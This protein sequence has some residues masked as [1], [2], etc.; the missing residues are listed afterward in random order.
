MR[1]RWLKLAVF[2]SFLLTVHSATSE[3]KH[4]PTSTTIIPDSLSSCTVRDWKRV[5]HA[6]LSQMQTPVCPLPM[7][8]VQENNR[9]TTLKTTKQTPSPTVTVSDEKSQDLNDPDTD[10][11]LDNANFLSFDEWKKQNLA[12]IGQSVE[13]VRGNRRASD[14][15]KES[16]RRPTGI[17]NAL[18][19]F[20]DE[21]EIEINFAGF[22]AEPPNTA[23][24]SSASWTAVKDEEEDE[25][26]QP[27]Q[28]Q[29]VD[30]K[31][32]DDG[33]ISPPSVEWTGTSRE[34]DAGT[35]CK[36]RFNYASF[37]CAATVLKTNPQCQGS[38]SVLVEN[39]D[40][41]MLNEC[42]A[43]DKLLILELCDDIL[44]DTVVLAN[45]EFFSSIF[46][47]FR[48][49]VSDRYPAKQPGQWKELGVY[50]ARNTREVQAFP[51][52]NPLIWARYLKIEFLTHYGTEFYCPLSLVRV[53]GTTMME[54]Y[55][56]DWETGRLDDGI[57]E[58]AE[59]EA[60]AAVPLESND[61]E[62]IESPEPPA[63]SEEE[64]NQ[65]EQHS[66]A[67]IIGS[68][69]NIQA[70][71]IRV[72]LGSSCAVI[73]VC[74]ASENTTVTVG[75]GGDGEVDNITE[76]VQTSI[77]SA[78]ATVESSSVV[79]STTTVVTSTDMDRVIPKATETTIISSTSTR[80]V[81]SETVIRNATETETKSTT[82]PTTTK[83]EPT[84][85]TG[86]SETRPTVAQPSPHPTTQESF[87]KSVNK[88]LQMLETNS[89]LSLLYIE[90]QSRILREAFQKVEKRQLTKTST[91]L[92]N[93]NTTVLGEL[94]Q[95]REQ[96]EDVWNLVTVEFNN[97]KL[98]YHKEIFSFSSQLSL[99]TDELVF[100]KRLSVI[101]SIVVLFCF[102]FVVFS[103]PSS[104]QPYGRRSA[105]SRPRIRTMIHPTRSSLLSFV[106]S[107]SPS[108]TSST[109][110]P[111][112]Y[113]RDTDRDDSTQSR[114]I[115]H[116]DSQEDEDDD[117][118]YADADGEVDADADADTDGINID[119][120][121]ATATRTTPRSSEDSV[122]EKIQVV[123]DSSPED[124]VV[125][126]QRSESSPPVLS[127]GV[128]GVD[129][130]DDH[131]IG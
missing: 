76:P 4:I 102:G 39:K 38:S 6:E 111:S 71:V 91:F 82:K 50:E 54:E 18:E 126:A 106:G 49:S 101:Q 53:H 90:E 123:D 55:K 100:Q 27:Q 89:T 85:N 45:Y 31:I 14:V 109:T 28:Q 86:T 69:A 1:K 66:E 107:R 17:S 20:G 94:K 68:C 70:E 73:D 119:S 63:V 25:G 125:M 16:R 61:S 48:V 105:Y 26:M 96:Y 21:S 84:P 24:P 62:P 43:P 129:D 113:R 87:F 64:Q 72:L 112:L 81:A 41:Y 110:S 79:Q 57:G 42:R 93:L 131:D 40:S 67:L 10:S 74:P 58:A 88:R 11:L 60:E 30:G 128:D 13:N 33:L 95:F 19:S 8:P 97:Q 52:T 47:T 77:I 75:I 51:V 56:H 83:E 34:R 3:E 2:F 9:V 124:S 116:D 117:E 104:I 37:D 59:A 118:E 92:E 122:E 127:R 114:P 98:R 7:P 80:P 108:P 103:R 5:Q 99:L 12:K 120:P 115:S 22:R 29:Y 78:D 32:V 23:K 36:E 130:V 65:E 44:V 121:I 15:S 46:H 35:T